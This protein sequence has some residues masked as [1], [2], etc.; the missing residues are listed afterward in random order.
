MT[1]QVCTYS[2]SMAD[3]DIDPKPW[4][5]P[6]LARLQS[7]GLRF[8]PVKLVS[9]PAGFRQVSNFRDREY[10]RRY[11][12]IQL[13]VDDRFDNSAVTFYTRAADGEINGTARLVLDS[14]HGLPEESVLARYARL[15]RQRGERLAEFGRFVIDD[16]RLSLVRHYYASI[17]HTCQF[18]EVDRLVLLVRQKE[19]AFYQKRVGASVLCEDTGLTF[20]SDHRFAALSWSIATTGSRFLD[21]LREGP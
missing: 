6:W 18:L 16:G 13:G 2:S 10:A 9:H 3:I 5:N 8:G 1:N 7:A 4:S 21:W 14:K 17:Y 19:L 15:W 12:A 20:G 11:P